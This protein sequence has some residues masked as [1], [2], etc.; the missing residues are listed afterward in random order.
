MTRS[1]LLIATALALGLAGCSKPE[2]TAATV[3]VKLKL[4]DRA[5]TPLKGVVVTLTPTG[6]DNA[7]TRPTTPV[8]PDG[9]ATLECLPGSYTAT[10][11]P[12]PRQGHADAPG[13][14]ATVDHPS[15]ADAPGKK[16]PAS[17]SYRA[18][19]ESPWQIEVKPE[20]NGEFVLRMY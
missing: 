3:S 10:I 5:G 20:G 9:T 15:K 2:P 18:V 6:A 16:G 8:Q 12:L 19:G 7:A 14:G 1:D 11:A 13:E 17:I 4:L